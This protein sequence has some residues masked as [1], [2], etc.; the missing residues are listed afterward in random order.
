[1]IL[2]LS[3]FLAQGNLAEQLLAKLQSTLQKKEGPPIASSD[4]PAKNAGDRSLEK[5]RKK[6]ASLPRMQ[7]DDKPSGKG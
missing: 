5:E 1:M 7:F 4:A 2:L 6:D 3:V